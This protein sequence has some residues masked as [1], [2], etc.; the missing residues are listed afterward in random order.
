MCMLKNIFPN[1]QVLT[2]TV[3]RNES[4]PHK[5]ASLPTITLEQTHSNNFQEVSH[6]TTATVLNCDAVIT[7]QTNLHLKI[8][9]A[10]CLPILIYHPKPLIAAIHAGRKGTEQRIITHVLDYL[11][12]THR[13]TNKLSMWFGPAI[14]ETCYQVD[15]KTD[16]HYN[17]IAKNNDQIRSLYDKTEADILYSNFCTAHQNEEYFSYRKE[18]K[19]VPMNWSGITLI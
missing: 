18:S 2:Y 17:L 14:C 6:L 1:S 11:R 12:T 13:I 3:G 8:K 9:H 4:I 10:D 5:I 16:Q 19:G 15:K 7:T